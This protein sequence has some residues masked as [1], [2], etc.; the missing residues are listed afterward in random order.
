MW[1]ILGLT[2]G[3]ICVVTQLPA[4]A[5]A[6]DWGYSAISVVVAVYLVGTLTL[7]TFIWR[8]PDASALATTDHE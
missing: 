1:W 2:W 5:A 8:E 7:R 6:K 3:L 4:A